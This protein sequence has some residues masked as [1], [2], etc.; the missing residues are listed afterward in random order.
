MRTLKDNA[1][2]NKASDTLYRFIL[3][4]LPKV[5]TIDQ[6][7][8]LLLNCNTVFLP[9]ISINAMQVN[10][11]GGHMF[12]PSGEISFDDVTLIFLIDEKL[13]N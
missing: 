6:S 1:T 12:A 8:S 3:T 13:E 4:D 10:W 2:L 9:G 11:Q 5:L 7:R